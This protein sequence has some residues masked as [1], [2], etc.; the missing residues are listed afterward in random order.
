MEKQRR[1]TS[2]RL[3]E[4][5]GEK[6]LDVDRFTLSLGLRRVAEQT[7]NSQDLLTKD[8]RALLEAYAAGVNDFIQ[9]IG[10]FK[11]DS[12]A[13]YLPPEFYALGLHTVDPW[14]P[15][16]SLCLLRLMNFHLSYNWNMDLVR[17]L[18]KDLDDGALAS[19]VEELVTFSAEHAHNLSTS[20]ND[21]DMRRAGLWSEKTLLERYKTK[22]PMDWGDKALHQEHLERLRKMEAELEEV[23]Q[24]SKQN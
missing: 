9:G 8:Q 19:M 11:E 20:L 17:D 21:E 22:T 5:F 6:T 18:V 10:Y 1:F 23:E 24:L 12:T 4:V 7:W 14:H 13:F 2:G 16:D 3:S 15:V